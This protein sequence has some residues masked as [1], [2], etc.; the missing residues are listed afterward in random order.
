M[1]IQ[2]EKK[3]YNDDVDTNNKRHVTIVNSKN[4]KIL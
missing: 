3:S 4:Y 2:I 1:S